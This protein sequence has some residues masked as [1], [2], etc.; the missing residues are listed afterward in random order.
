[1]QK[2]EPANRPRRGTGGRRPSERERV[3]G[4]RQERAIKRKNVSLM[5]DA[6]KLSKMKTEKSVHQIWGQ[7]GHCPEETHTLGPK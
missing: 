3:S 1:M 4:P 7:E 6:E 5:S 2:A